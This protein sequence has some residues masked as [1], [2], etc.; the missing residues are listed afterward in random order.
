VLIEVKGRDGKPVK[1]VRNP[2][3]M[4]RDGPSVER[5]P[6]RIGEHSEEV[7]GG[8]GYT[9]AQIDALVTAGVTRL[10]NRDGGR[11]IEKQKERASA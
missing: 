5:L 11:R 2:V 7:L 1:A 4:D 3:L 8:L 9:A 6:P 10:G